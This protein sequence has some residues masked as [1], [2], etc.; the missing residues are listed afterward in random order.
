MEP[1]GNCNSRQF[2]GDSENN[3]RAGEN[4]IKVGENCK[5]ARESVN[6]AGEDAEYENQRADGRVTVGEIR[7]FQEPCEYGVVGQESEGSG[8]F[9]ITPSRSPRNRICKSNGARATVGMETRGAEYAGSW[10]PGS[11]TLFVNRWNSA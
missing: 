11:Q 8:E 3:N 10:D 5:G 1:D 4:G 9:D 2:S 7:E 6:G